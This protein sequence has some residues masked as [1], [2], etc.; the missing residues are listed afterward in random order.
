MQRQI[1]KDNSSG[2]VRVE[3]DKLFWKFENKNILEVD[4][5]A[6]VVIG[7]YT[8]SD[9]PYFDDW[10]LTFVTKDGQW[11]SIPWYTDNIDEV[12]QYLTNRFHQNL[13]ATHLANSTNWKSVIRY[14]LHLEGKA[15]F[16][17]TPSDNYKAPKTFF[18]KILSSVGFGGFDTTQNIALTEEVKNEVTNASR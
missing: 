9:G 7:E 8:N 11:Y 12:T 18:D 10:F 6:V 1:T 4:M 13:S 14:P 3:N 2:I 17:L 5:E 16:T 15:L